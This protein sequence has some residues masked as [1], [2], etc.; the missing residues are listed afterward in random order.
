MSPKINV[1]AI[2]S[3]LDGP[4]TT[5]A[6]IAEVERAMKLTDGSVHSASGRTAALA[7]NFCERNNIDYQLTRQRGRYFVQRRA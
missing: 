7:V 1:F 2:G 4:G 6:L 5:R 3:V